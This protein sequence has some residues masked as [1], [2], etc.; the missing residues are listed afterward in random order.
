MNKIMEMISKIPQGSTFA[1]KADDKNLKIAMANRSN[2]KPT[3]PFDGQQGFNNSEFGTE[4]DQFATKA[5]GKALFKVK[6]QHEGGA[7]SP[8]ADQ[9]TQEPAQGSRML[10]NEEIKEICQKH[11][12]TRG[13][14]YSIRSQFAS[15]CSLS[16]QWLKQK[17]QQTEGGLFDNL[18]ANEKA[19]KA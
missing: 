3:Q 5:A 12:L 1:S 17:D 10:Q 7:A 2:L 14:V 9:T 8:R 6:T 13:E 19:Q 18:A 4:E 15:M 16:E 11:A